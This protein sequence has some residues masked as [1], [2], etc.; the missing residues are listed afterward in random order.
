M[1][2]CLVVPVQLVE[3]AA[4]LAPGQHE[5][6]TE[7]G[8]QCLMLGDT[9]GAMDAFRQAAKLNQMSVEALHG[10]VRCQVSHGVAHPDTARERPVIAAPEATHTLLSAVSGRWWTGSWRTRSSR[11]SS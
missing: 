6:L 5:Y 3:R 2:P 7:V 11:W 10:M 4:K 9:V 1:H 8:N